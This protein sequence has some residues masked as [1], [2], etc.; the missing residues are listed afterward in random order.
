MFF[1]EALVSFHANLYFRVTVWTQGML[2]AT[3][4]VIISS[5]FEWTFSSYWHFE[6]KI[7]IN[8][9][10]YIFIS[11]FSTPTISIFID[12]SDI[13]IKILHNNL[14]VSKHYTQQSQNK[15]TNPSTNMNTE[16]KQKMHMLSLFSP[17]FLIVAQNPHCQGICLM[18]NILPPFKVPCGLR[19][20]KSVVNVLYPFLCVG[21]LVFWSSL[22][23]R[24][25]GSHFLSCSILNIVL[26]FSTGINRYC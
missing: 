18:H 11:F 10:Y 19:T 23:V 17:N 5:H 6:F 3:G 1:E 21:I 8:F 14:F 24:F 20:S 13:R 9:F 16:N 12:K 15:N 2:I 25:L 26:H 22:S 4:L 7:L